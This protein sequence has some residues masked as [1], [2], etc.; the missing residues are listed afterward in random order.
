MRTQN[1][2]PATAALALA[3]GV[4]A[5]AALAPTAPAQERPRQTPADL[6]A[7]MQLERD[8]EYGRVGNLALLMDTVR[9]RERPSAPMPAIVWVHGGAW[10]GGAKEGGILRL[11]PFA[12]DGYF[13]AS[14]AY[15]LSGEA[16]WPAQI[17][18]CKC[19]VRY[20]RAHARE[21]H[22]D[23][24]RIGAWGAS[25]GGHLVALLG[26]TAG[27]PELEGDAGW[28]EQSSRVQAVCDWYGPTDLRGLASVDAVAD[29]LGSGS[30]LARRA[31]Q[32]SPLTH[33]TADDAPF[34]IMHGT[35][36][37]VVAPQQSRA[38]YDALKA[39]G[40]PA[41]LMMIDGA[42][43]GFRDPRR[44]FLPVKRFFDRVLKGVR[45]AEADEPG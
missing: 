42:G 10:S 9:P 36:D 25:A 3:A 16:T 38:L 41:R 8:V 37:G 24:D 34:L 27:A 15:R 13:G 44:T 30:G 18:D 4:I 43:H 35:E 19:A 11:L 5:L 12:Q 14:V 40:V 45:P 21:L 20:L 1:H 2:T 33:V 39:A 23:P 26:T 31:A 17:Q 7:Q 32:A 28:P 29:M 22:I 6:L